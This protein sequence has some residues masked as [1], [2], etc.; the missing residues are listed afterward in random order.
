MA[1]PLRIPAHRHAPTLPA[2]PQAA[3]PRDPNAT[4]TETVIATLGS[5]RFVGLGGVPLVTR[6]AGGV[7]DGKRRAFL[8]DLAPI[9]AGVV[10][11]LDMFARE[12]GRLWNTALPAD[13][14]AGYRQNPPAGTPPPDLCAAVVVLLRVGLLA[15][16]GFK[17]DAVTRTGFEPSQ[18]GYLFIRNEEGLAPHIYWPG[19]D[20]SGVTVGPGYDMGNRTPNQIIR[21][22]TEI[23]VSTSAANAAADGARLQGTA[24]GAF[25]KANRG[26]LNLTPLQQQSLF[27]LVVPTYVDLVR[28]IKPRSLEPRLLQHEFDVMLSLA[29]NLR[30]Y[31]QYNFN[32]DISMLNMVKADPD[33][34]TLTKGGPG[35][36]ARRVRETLL[37]TDA[38]YN[39]KPLVMRDIDINYYAEIPP[40][41]TSL[42]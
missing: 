30:R 42:G 4:A 1:S 17:V 15:I 10:L 33:I 41:T 2:A 3:L 32:I 38:I 22:L 26:I 28:K 11:P 37:F 12:M 36:S 20:N 39:I 9:R 14:P 6:K 5:W 7:A 19:N 16:D 25:V 13:F 23:G 31:G 34:K 18:L 35:L 40:G 27:N 29:W 24:A 21:D 8:N